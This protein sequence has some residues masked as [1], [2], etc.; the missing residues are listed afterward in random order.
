M[1]NYPLEQLNDHGPDKDTS[2]ATDPLRKRDKF[3]GFFGI[4]KV[5]HKVKAK[6]STQSL[7]SQLSPQKL[8]PS[9]GASQVNDNQD[10]PLPEVPTVD[11]LHMDI[12]PE[13]VPKPAN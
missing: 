7:K 1:N 9:S 11:P 8:T 3:L 5:D 2:N 6:I 10:K 12:F 13:N 4:Q